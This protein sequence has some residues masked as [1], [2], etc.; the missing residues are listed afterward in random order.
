MRKVKKLIN[1]TSQPRC[2][3]TQGELLLT[4]AAVLPGLMRIHT[5]E[6]VDTN[7]T[8]ATPAKSLSALAVIANAVA[9]AGVLQRSRA[10]TKRQHDDKQ[11]S[12]VS[13]CFVRKKTD[14]K[15]R[16]KI[17]PLFNISSSCG[18]TDVSGWA[19]ASSGFK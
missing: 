2:N 13:Q 8:A 3:Q 5:P 9:V 10:P 4:K 15:Q 6:T 7:S 1:L 14:L 11:V 18:P 16:K 19:E 12:T 17:S